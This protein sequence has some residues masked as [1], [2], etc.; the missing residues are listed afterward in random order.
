MARKHL[1]TSIGSNAADRR[2]AA[3]PSESRA[4]Y[5][6]RGASRSMMQSLDEMAENSMRVFEG[7]TIVSLDPELLEPSPFADRIDSDDEEFAALVAA[8][9]QAG[10]SSPVLVRPHPDAAGRFIIV[11]GHRRA[12]AARQLGINVRAVVKPIED[13]AHVIAQGQENT[14]RSDLTFIEKALFARKLTGSGIDKETIKSA[15]TIDDTL[16]SRMLAVAEHVPED[17][18]NSL[19]SARGIGRDRWEEL[20]KLMLVPGKAEL[21]CSLACSEAIAKLP[22]ADRF[23]ALLSGLKSS[24]RSKKSGKPKPSE[25][26]WSLAENSVKVATKDVGTAFTLALKAKDASRFG[27]Y[28]SQNLEQLYEEF[29]RTEN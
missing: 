27:A 7:E 13:I 25:R 8:I 6:R 22:M 4:E 2:T 1:L 9:G 26:A 5:A 23:Q 24:G 12:R 11:Y 19:G 14:A 18:L 17:V 15:L 3:D 29:K 21:A 20:K 16:L 28:I 10:Q